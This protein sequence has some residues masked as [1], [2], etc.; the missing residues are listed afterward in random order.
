MSDEIPRRLDELA[1]NQAGVVSRKQALDCGVSV[2]QINARIKFGRWR[3]VHRAVYSTH[4][5]P[6]TRNAR[7]WAAVLYA[8]R[9][10]RLSHETAAEVLGLTDRPAPRIQISVDPERRVAPAAGLITYRSACNGRIWRPPPGV[11]PHTTEEDTVLDLVDAATSLDDVIGW[12][13]RAL[14]KPITSEPHLRQAM[15]ERKRLRWRRELDEII[16]AAAGGAHSVLEYRHDRDVQ[17]AHGLPVPKRQVPFR[18]PDGTR[19]YL[20]RYYPE[21]RLV[22]ELD[23]RQYHPDEQ[24]A[25]D[26][27]RDNANAVT[28]STLRYGW[29]DVTRRACEVARQEADALR[30]RGWADDLKPCS[31]GCRAAYPARPGLIRPHSG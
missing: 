11:P 15:A 4:G 5:G 8:G 20:D 17:R 21:Y 2:G 31:P 18:K 9:S 28:G 19:G 14:A 27:A 22:I 24:H 30:G 26:Q 16:A 13:T 7:L 29:N 3:P 25:R 23:G 12:V 10:A 1:R 6:L